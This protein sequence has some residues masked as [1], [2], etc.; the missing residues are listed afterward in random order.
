MTVNSNPQLEFFSSRHPPLDDGD[1][2]IEISQTICG[3]GISEANTVPMLTRLFSVF[4]ER[5]SLKPSDIHAVFPPDRSLGDYA[6][7]LPHVILNRSTLPWERRIE[8]TND[9]APWLALLLFTEDELKSV[10][11]KVVT[12]AKLKKSAA[13]PSWPKI[14]HEAGQADQDS[15][16]IID[17]PLVTAKMV[18]P[19]GE[20]LPHLAHVRQVSGEKETA[21]NSERA[22]IIGS[23][24]PVGQKVMVA[25]LVSLENRYIKTEKKDKE[26]KNTPSWQFNWPTNGAKTVRFVTLKSWSFQC[27]SPQ[28][29]FGELLKGLDAGALKR[30]ILKKEGQVVEPR[31]VQ[32]KIPLPHKMRSGSMSYCWYGG[33]YRR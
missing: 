16:T 24:L 26:G 23:R 15:V 4:G 3:T 18:V 8:K 29:T 1:Y 9:Q 19:C 5:F 2:T 25:H 17:I 27:K 30:A 14:S 20:E 10:Q 6:T 21:E 7:V 12:V 11:S 33:R 31:L 22:V 13:D 28:H 32:G